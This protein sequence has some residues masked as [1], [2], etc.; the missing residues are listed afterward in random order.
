[1]RTTAKTVTKNHVRK[2]KGV[3]VNEVVDRAV[4]LRMETVATIAVVV[5]AVARKTIAHA[6]LL[7]RAAVKVVARGGVKALMI[8]R[9]G[10]RFLVH[11][12]KKISQITA[13]SPVRALSTL[14]SCVVSGL[15]KLESTAKMPVRLCLQA[16]L[17]LLFAHGLFS[18]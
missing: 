9:L 8:V 6:V 2:V 14:S 17:T 1:M 12:M 15:K 7:V 11:R 10:K 4:V 16:A 5:K 3:K 13:V 18:R